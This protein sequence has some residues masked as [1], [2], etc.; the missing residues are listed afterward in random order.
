MEKIL[1]PLFKNT[2][3]ALVVIGLFFILIGAAGGVEKLALVIDNLAWR[4][5][6]SGMGTVVSLFAAL[7]I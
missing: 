1:A 7:L 3:L 6:I 5:A 2:P 4:I